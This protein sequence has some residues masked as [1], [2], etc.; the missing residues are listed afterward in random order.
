M[1]S[2]SSHRDR[3]TRLLD[4]ETRHIDQGTRRVP[5]QVTM[6]FDPQKHHWRSIRLKGYDY[7]QPGFTRDRVMR[8]LDEET[9]H[10]DQGTRRVPLQDNHGI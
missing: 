6:G 10:I 1:G 4:E 9:R 2:R 7:I 5:L 3:V 8:L